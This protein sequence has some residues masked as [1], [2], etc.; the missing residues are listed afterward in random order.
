LWRE[1]E[2]L[3][4]LNTDVL[5]VSFEQLDRIAWYLAEAE[6]GWPVLSD[7]GRDAYRAYRLERA[8]FARA[9]LSPRTLAY[10][11]RQILRG[12]PPP[13]PRADSLQLG[14]DFLVDDAGILRLA[15]PSSEPADRPSLPEILAAIPPP[16]PGAG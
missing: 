1:R 6:F 3:E 12:H 4:V 16:A 13:I 9:W 10:Y 14:G 5:L 15:R 8:G 11:A 7:P 2:T